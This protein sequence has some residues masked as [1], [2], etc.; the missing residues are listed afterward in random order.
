MV[1]VA[2]GYMCH[3]WGDT[4]L[5]HQVGKLNVQKHGRGRQAKKE[6]R[7]RKKS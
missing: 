6:A 1:C 3:W 2:N 7:L 5:L 4:K